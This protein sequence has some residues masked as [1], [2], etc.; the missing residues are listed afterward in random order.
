MM[1][2]L[3]CSFHV[4]LF[5]FSPFQ[6]RGYSP[7]PL[8]EG[9]LLTAILPKMI[10]HDLLPS[11]GSGNLVQERHGDQPQAAQSIGSQ[12]PMWWMANGVYCRVTWCYIA[13]AHSVTSACLHHRPRATVHQGTGSTFPYSVT[14]SGH[15]TL[16]TH[17]DLPT[18]SSSSRSSSAW[19]CTKLGKV[20]V[21]VS[22]RTELIFLLVAGRMLFWLRMRRVLITHQCF[23]CCRAVLTASQGH[24][25]FLLCPANGQAGGTGRAGRGQ[26]QDR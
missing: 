26:T 12:T 8:C 11:G 25:S 6:V 13:E 20:L 16:T 24:L 21:L 2:C 23:N 22:G 3:R 18:D 10:L 19:I 1:L 14:S 9:S 15:Q 4:S 7:P 5:P 17:N